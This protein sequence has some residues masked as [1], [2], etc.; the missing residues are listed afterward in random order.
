MKYIVRGNLRPK[1]NRQFARVNKRTGKAYIQNAPPNVASWETMIPQVNAV[2]DRE[3]FDSDVC[4]RVTYYRATRHRVDTTNLN[5][6][7]ADILEKSGVVT[8]DRHL[9]LWADPVQHDKEDP[10]VEFWIHE[11]SASDAV[12]TNR[13]KR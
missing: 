6:A 4:F 2:W 7:F 8:D 13:G 10:R 3:P 11:E 1:K 12:D 5:S 9:R